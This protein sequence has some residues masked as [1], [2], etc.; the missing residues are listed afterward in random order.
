MST[1]LLHEEEDELEAARELEAHNILQDDEPAECPGGS[2]AAP[3]PGSRARRLTRWRPAKSVPVTRAASHKQTRQ[4]QRL[5][6]RKMGAQTVYERLIEYGLLEK[7]TNIALSKAAVPWGL[8]EDAIQ[9]VHAYW[10]T[11]VVKPQFERNQVACYAYMAGRHAALSLRRQLGATVVLPGSLFRQ[12]NRSSSFLE[13]IGAAVNPWDVDAVADSLEL[14]VDTR[15]EHSQ[16]VTPAF[17]RARL[18]GLDLTERQKSLAHMVLIDGLTSIEAAKKLGLSPAHVDRLIVQ[19]ADRLELNESKDPQ[20]I[21][22]EELAFLKLDAKAGLTELEQAIARGL[23]DVIA[24]LTQEIKTGERT[25]D[26]I[27]IC[28]QLSLDFAEPSCGKRKAPAAGRASLGG[29]AKRRGRPPGSGNKTKKG[30]SPDEGGQPANPQ[31]G[32]A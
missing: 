16:K 11:L 18:A 10:C 22:K 25:K 2:R 32:S 19:I 29:P 8:R 7:L 12:D 9:E 23:P 17:L 24:E 1:L 5:E 3:Q 21:T 31:S 13:S 14:S 27:L 4:E 30:E 15:D 20:L 28:K 6:A 26:G